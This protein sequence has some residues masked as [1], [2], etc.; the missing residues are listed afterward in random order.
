MSSG[1]LPLKTYHRAQALGSGAYGSVLTVYNDDGEE[2][3]LKLFDDDSDSSDDDYSTEDD[4][5]DEED[6]ESEATCPYNTLELGALREISLL[7][8]LRGENA[9]PNVIAI[10]DVKQTNDVCDDEDEYNHDASMDY[11]GITMPLF[12]S[13][14]LTNAIES[15]SLSKRNKV[16]I[17]HG[18]L[19]AV[20]YLHTN[21]IIHRDIKSDNVMIEIDDDGN[22]KPVLI[23]F[24]LAKIIQPRHMYSK[25]STPEAMKNFL[26]EALKDV[27][28]TP[29]IGTPTYRSPECYN[30]E[31]Y[32]FPSDLYS[33]GVILLELIRDQCLET[34]RD[35][36]AFKLVQEECAKLPDQ[37]F[38]NLIRKLIDTNPELR[39]TARDALSNPVF[40][41]FGFH[42]H[43]KTFQVI[44]ICEALPLDMDEENMSFISNLKMPNSKLPKPVKKRVELI[45]KI[46]SALECEHPM[47]IVAALEYSIQ[48]S[49]LEDSLDDVTE[50][51]GLI[52][53]VVF[54]ASFFE[55]EDFTLS[56]VE[57]LDTGIFKQCNWSAETYQDSEY[58]IFMLMDFCVYPRTLTIL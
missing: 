21:G 24:S 4:D 26:D 42:V 18:L 15:K 56:W 13:G 58:T 44:D 22:Y 51:Q 45:K 57:S 48:L 50:S 30:E 16:G 33:I 3:A 49:Q 35:K 37:P 12:H 52:D 25:A 1:S 53:C 23:D 34:Y 38:P 36:A 46:A 8:L 43:D 9:H 47:T 41:K 54:A 17:A 31:S 27:T 19:S 14:T 10:S 55:Y 39:P 2:F 32:G 6:Y 7:R 20:A 28:H 5:S 40:E 29:G 11:L